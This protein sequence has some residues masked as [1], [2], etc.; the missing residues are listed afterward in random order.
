[1]TK[2][3]D[4]IDAIIAAGVGGRGKGRDGGPLEARGGRDGDGTRSEGEGAAVRRRRLA[5]CSTTP[6]G[7]PPEGGTD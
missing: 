5:G 1:M 6:A 7:P 4:S 2:S 3:C